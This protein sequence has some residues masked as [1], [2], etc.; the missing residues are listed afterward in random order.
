MALLNASPGINNRRRIDGR[1]TIDSSSSSLLEMLE[2]LPL[3]SANRR[4][5][6]NRS[7][8]SCTSSS[9]CEHIDEFRLFRRNDDDDDDDDAKSVSTLCDSMKHSSLNDSSLCCSFL[10]CFDEIIAV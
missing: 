3:L 4:T 6:S 8:A 9:S 7:S 2:L 5:K 1:V 10:A